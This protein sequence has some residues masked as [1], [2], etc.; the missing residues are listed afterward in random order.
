MIAL[1]SVVV[2]WL[3]ARRAS[4]F[5]DVALGASLGGLAA[6]LGIA[7][8]QFQCMFQQAPHLLVWHGGTAALL[9]SLA[10]LLAGLVRHRWAS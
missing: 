4:L 6:L 2:F 7:V 5:P 3:L 10:A 9:V 1:P 8:L